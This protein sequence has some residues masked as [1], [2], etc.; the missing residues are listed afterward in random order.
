MDMPFNLNFQ[1]DMHSYK[2]MQFPPTFPPNQSSM[3]PPPLGNSMPPMPFSMN[4]PYGAPQTDFSFPPNMGD[5]FM[6]PS[7]NKN[8]DFRG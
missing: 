3:F 1:E 8:M 7:M 4:P 5:P 2:P 6:N